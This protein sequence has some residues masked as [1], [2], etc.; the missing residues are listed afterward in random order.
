M[1]LANGE[2]L[3]ISQNMCLILETDTL[4]NVTP[5]TISRCGLIFADR[6]ELSN[7]KQVF[8]QYLNRLPP[9]LYEQTKDLEL[10]IN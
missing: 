2:T 6:K 8:N 9:N 4:R 3:K 1:T 7:P 10:W 5:A